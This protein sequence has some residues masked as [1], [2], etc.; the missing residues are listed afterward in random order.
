[1]VNHRKP[2]GPNY[3]GVS[4]MDL[5]SSINRF[6]ET[7][8]VGR[9][10]GVGHGAPRRDDVFGTRLLPCRCPLLADLLHGERIIVDFVDTAGERLS[11]ALAAAAV[12]DTN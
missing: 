11:V 2:C 1:M 6:P 5:G 9:H 10:A 3:F 12:V 8:K 4:E 7:R